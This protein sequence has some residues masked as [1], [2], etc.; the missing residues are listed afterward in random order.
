MKKSSLL[1]IR[2][3][4]HVSINVRFLLNVLIV[5]ELVIFLVDVFIRTMKLVMMRK[6]LEM[7]ETK[8]KGIKESSSRR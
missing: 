4:E 7:R 5:V 2:K 6:T 1:E 3:D 8:K